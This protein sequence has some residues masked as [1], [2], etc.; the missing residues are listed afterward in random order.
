L[1]TVSYITYAEAIVNSDEDKIVIPTWSLISCPTP[2][3]WTEVQNRTNFMLSNGSGLAMQQTTIHACYDSSFLYLYFQCVDNN[4]YNPYTTCNQPLYQY[5]AVETFI[6]PTW[7]DSKNYFEFEVS[8][9]GVL[10]AARVANPDGTCDGIQ[11]NL[12][13]CASTGI[14]Y[15]ATRD[16]AGDSWTAYLQI[17]WQLLNNPDEQSDS[18]APITNKWRIN[19]F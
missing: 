9:N 17:P 6:S 7:V 11:D 18:T 1:I 5:S 14:I 16:D 13:P 12:I 10:F 4:I 8:P 15:N 19:F 2:L 3:V